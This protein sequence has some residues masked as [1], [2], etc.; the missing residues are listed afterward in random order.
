MPRALLDLARHSYLRPPAELV[1]PAETASL[2]TV[3]AV[4]RAQANQDFRGYKARTLLRRIHRRM[5]LHRI[6]ELDRYVEWLRSDPE[7]VAALARDLTINVTGFFRD[8]EAWQVLD[9]KIIEPLVQQRPTGT[10][11][12]RFMSASPAGW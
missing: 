5:G 8:P 3:L 7:E 11:L 10:T 2:D 6:E 4:V 9:E 1:V 12:R